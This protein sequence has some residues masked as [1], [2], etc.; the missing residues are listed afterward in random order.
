MHGVQTKRNGNT[1]EITLSTGRGGNTQAKA[2]CVFS[3]SLDL[4]LL[5]K[6]LIGFRDTERLSGRM[7]KMLP[8]ECA[9]LFAVVLFH[10]WL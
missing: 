5:S 2:V 6:L 8:K 9:I 4:R 3:V 7:W 10:I 1:N